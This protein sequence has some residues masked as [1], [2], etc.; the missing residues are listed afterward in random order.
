MDVIETKFATK[1]Y[2]VYRKTISIKDISDHTMREKAF[3]MVHT[4]IRENN[5]TIAG[6]GS[7]LYFTW[8]E[9]KNQT[10]MAIGMPITTTPEITNSEL[11]MVSVPAAKAVQLTV[12][13]DYKQFQAAHSSIREYIKTHNLTSTLA[14]E[15]YTVTGMDKKDSSEWETNIYYLV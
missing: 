1:N 7:A 2:L 14:I 9:E 3:W 5:L 13:G 10:D 11:S 12:H 4:Y 6:A 15:E 8:D